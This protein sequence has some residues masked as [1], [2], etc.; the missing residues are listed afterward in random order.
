MPPA[1]RIDGLVAAKRA[2]ILDVFTREILIRGFATPQATPAEIARPAEAC[3]SALV[4]A[5]GP[6]TLYD[7]EKMRLAD[8]Y[9]AQR[10]RLGYDLRALLTEFGVLRAITVDAVVGATGSSDALARVVDFLHDV[11]VE[12]ALGFSNRTDRAR[13]LT[14]AA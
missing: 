4:R 5:L 12:A 6:S 7:A 14:P 10:I 3:L 2:A 11:M 9:A 1:I 13:P 8:E